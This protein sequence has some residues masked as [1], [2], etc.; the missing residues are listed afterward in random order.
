MFY[1][2]RHKRFYDNPIEGDALIVDGCSMIDIV[3][4]NSLMKALPATKCL[5]LVGDIDQLPSVGAAMHSWI[6]LIRIR[7]PLSG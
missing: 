2:C 7:Y 4:M 1:F 6:S 3:L 5:I